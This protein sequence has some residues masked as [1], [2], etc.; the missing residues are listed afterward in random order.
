MK[1]IIKIMASMTTTTASRIHIKAIIMT[2]RIDDT[3]RAMYWLIKLNLG[4]Q[5]IGLHNDLS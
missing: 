2:T 3:I 5:H 1:T 4:S